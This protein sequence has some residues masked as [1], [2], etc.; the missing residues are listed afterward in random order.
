MPLVNKILPF[1]LGSGSNVVD[2]ATWTAATE[3]STGFQAGVA[4][5]SKVNKSL[6]QSSVIA[7]MV[8]QFIVDQANV[9]VNDDGDLD[10]LETN[11]GLAINAAVAAAIQNQ[12]GNYAVDTGSADAL[13]VTLPTIPSSHVNARPIRF[14]KSAAANATTTPTI[15]VNGIGPKTLVKSDGA[16]LAIGDLKASTRYEIFYDGTNY[17]VYG[18]SLASDVATQAPKT[19]RISQLQQAF[20]TST[21][22]STNSG[23]ATAFSMNFTPVTSSST[24]LIIA[25]IMHGSV[26][27]TGV[28]FGSEIKL[29]KTISGVTTDMTVGMKTRMY[30]DLSTHSAETISTLIAIDNAV[31]TTI[32]YDVQHQP[33]GANET[34]TLFQGSN[35]VVLELAP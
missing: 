35:F 28:D 14:L 11:L 6:R 22:Q 18:G 19:G 16:A 9:N 27:A 12:L 7:A 26:D 3:R 31:A 17:R 2:D 25:A 1:G 13:V 30:S 4:P 5:S 21:D 33:T 23:W 24:R 29:R 20:R 8:A 34:S 15:N 32:V 10:T